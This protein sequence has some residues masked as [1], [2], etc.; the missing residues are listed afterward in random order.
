[1]FSPG[2]LQLPT[3]ASHAGT[4]WVHQRVVRTLWG[5][6]W[7][8]AGLWA[9]AF[10]R[11]P[12]MATPC[13]LSE[14]LRYFA[15]SSGQLRRREEALRTEGS[16]KWRR[17]SASWGGPRPEQIPPTTRRLMLRWLRHRPS[18]LPFQAR[19]PPLLPSCFHFIQS[20][21]H[22]PA[23]L[24]PVSLWPVLPLFSVPSPLDTAHLSRHRSAALDFLFRLP[25]QIRFSD[26]PVPSWLDAAALTPVIGFGNRVL[27]ASVYSPGWILRSPGQSHVLYIF[28]CPVPNTDLKSKLETSLVVSS[29]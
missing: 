14:H 5:C 15:A 22:F 20:P 23:D 11:L 3:S 21:C 19:S 1:M 18:A 27:C 24:A 10:L 2:P 16:W 28:V 26:I 4:R 8:A 25:L 13:G 9:I 7:A 29:G 6:K 17:W 12:H